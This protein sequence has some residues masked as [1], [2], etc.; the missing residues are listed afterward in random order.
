MI[1]LALIVLPFL[2]RGDTRSIGKRMKYTTIGAIF[3]AE[4][5]V[6]TVW[7]KLTPGAVIPNEQ[8]VLI[9]GGTALLVALG[10]VVAYSLVFGGISRATGASPPTGG[11]V[12]RTASVRSRLQSASLWTACSFVGLLVVG[13]FGISGSLNA[14][15][16]MM[17]AGTTSAGLVYSLV[18]SLALVS[19]AVAGTAFL[20]YRLELST[21]AIRRRVRAFEVGWKG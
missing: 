16:G 13:S 20:V 10:S 4:V 6:L 7:G 5:A 9:L 11:P 14:V 17:A 3:V 15:A 18:A 12:V 8:A 21:G 1:F 2:D 19:V